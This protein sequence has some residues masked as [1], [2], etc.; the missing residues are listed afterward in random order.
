[1]VVIGESV[2]SASANSEIS[3]RLNTDSGSNYRNFGTNIYYPSGYSDSMQDRTGDLTGTKIPIFQLGASASGY[4]AG[5][6]L[7]SG[8]NASGVKIYSSVGG[9]NNAGT[10]GTQYFLG[11]IYNSATV[12][13]SIS[14]ISSSGNFDGGSVY[15]YTSA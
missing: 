9:V 14:V 3:I 8:A 1:M 12:I 5:Y 7:I 13:S 2:S 15:V 10:N 11:G 4:G 6:C